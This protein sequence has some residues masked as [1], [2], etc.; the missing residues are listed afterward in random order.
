MRLSTKTALTPAYKFIG[1]AALIVLG[2]LTIFN[3]LDL[4][5]PNVQLVRNDLITILPF[6]LS[7]ALY[8]F[9]QLGIILHFATGPIFRKFIYGLGI[10]GLAGLL[11]MLFRIAVVVYQSTTAPGGEGF[12]S[13]APVTGGAYYLG[14]LTKVLLGGMYLST[15]VI[16]GLLIHTLHRHV[17]NRNFLGLLKSTATVCLPA[18]GLLLASP[19]IRKAI[20]PKKKRTSADHLIP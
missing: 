16:L 10:T 12:D 7:A 4:Y 9:Y 3:F 1:A 14:L 19:S 17:F 6:L 20:Q 2:S 5:Y 13:I 8:F 11:F 15:F 18:I